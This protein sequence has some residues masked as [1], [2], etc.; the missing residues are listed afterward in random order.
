MAMHRMQTFPVQQVNQEHVSGA[1]PKTLSAPDCHLPCRDIPD[2]DIS[3]A[4]STNDQLLLLPPAICRIRHIATLK[5][6]STAFRT[7]ITRPKGSIGIIR[8]RWMTL[9]GSA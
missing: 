2:L 9:T 6:L 4:S 8:A 3:V 5:P 1:V 7:G